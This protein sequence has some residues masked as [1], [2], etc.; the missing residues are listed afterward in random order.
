VDEIQDDLNVCL[1]EG[2][3]DASY[4]NELKLDGYALVHKIN[5][6]IAYL[7]RTKQGDDP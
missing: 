6:Y 2:Y 4:V 5:S 1:D 7:R 3:G